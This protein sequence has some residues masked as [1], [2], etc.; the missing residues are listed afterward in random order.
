M[1]TFRRCIVE[2]TWTIVSPVVYEYRVGR[3]YS[4]PVSDSS[5]C[6][7]HLF[8]ARVYSRGSYEIAC[9]CPYVNQM[10]VG[11]GIHNLHPP[12]FLSAFETLLDERGSSLIWNGDFSFICALWTPEP[13]GLSRSRSKTAPAIH[14]TRRILPRAHARAARMP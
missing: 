7:T 2:A 13:S 1:S 4:C 14:L 10:H 9:S 5:L 12:S 8:A 6:F 11:L 3:R